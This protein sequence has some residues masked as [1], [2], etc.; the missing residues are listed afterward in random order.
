[1]LDGDLFE[2]LEHTADAAFVVTD[3]G[4][5][6]AWN[7]SAEALFGFCR[8]EAIGRTCFDLF[9]GRGALGTRVCSEQCHVRQCVVRHEQVPDFDLDVRTR[10]GRR[11][12]VNMSTVVSEDPRTGR[13][14]I[15]HLARGI[16]SRKRTDLLVDKILRLSRDLA[17]AHESPRFDPVVPLSEQEQRVLKGLSEGRS[18]SDIVTALHITPQTLRNHLHH[19]NQKLGTHTRLEAVIH[20]VR[21]QLI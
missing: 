7:A 2:L 13:R 14:R 10:S 15:V 4:E 16:T 17:D 19:I 12:W 1:M 11:I 8:A 5:I 6:C 21:R 3:A 20:A 9:Q 18:P